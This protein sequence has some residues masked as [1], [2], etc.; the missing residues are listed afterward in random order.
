MVNINHRYHILHHPF[1]QLPKQVSRLM[2]P[3]FPLFLQVCLV[4]FSFLCF[5]PVMT[6]QPAQGME[7]GATFHNKIKMVSWYHSLA[8]GQKRAAQVDGWVSCM[9]ET[10]DN[11]IWDLLSCHLAGINP[12]KTNHRDCLEQMSKICSTGNTR[13]ALYK[14]VGSELMQHRF[15]MKW[16]GSLMCFHFRKCP[17]SS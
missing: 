17:F 8:V 2:N 9:C 1:S 5:P 12:L 4:S 6:L 14:T 7:E 11:F 3:Q 16:H 13:R 15:H 10:L